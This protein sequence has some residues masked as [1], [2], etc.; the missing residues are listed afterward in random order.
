MT[1]IVYNEFF[2]LIVAGEKV[3]SNITRVVVMMWFFVVFILTASYTASLS[4]MLTVKQLEPEIDIEWLKRED[5]KVGCGDSFLRK[6]LENVL[7][8]K[9]KNIIDVVPHELNYL[10]KF[11]EGNIKAAFLEVP[12]EKVFLNKY[13]K[14][15]TTTTRTYRFGGLGFV[16][17]NYIPLHFSL[18][19]TISLEQCYSASVVSG[20]TTTHYGW[21]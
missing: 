7:K 17:I 6:Y 13:C 16:S 3:H 20:T 19:K 9:P 15:F 5:K 11:R 10:E 18:P 12:Y 1:C 8:F 21:T 4:S 2:C 14:D